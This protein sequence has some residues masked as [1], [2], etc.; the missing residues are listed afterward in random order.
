MGKRFTATEKW[1]KAWFR[2]L[3]PRHKALWEF[4]RDKC[5]AA[6][7]W[8]I[9]MDSATHYVNDL[10]PITMEDFKAFGDRVELHGSD[11]LWLSTFC[12]FQYENLSDKCPAHKPVFKLLRK[13]NLLNRV[14]NRVSNTLQEKEKESD[15]EKELEL[16]KDEGG[17]GETQTPPPAEPKPD[18]LADFEYWTDQV[19]AGNDVPFINLVRNNGIALDGSL[20]RLARDHLG[21]ASRYG[22]HEKT[23]TQHAFRLSLINFLKENLE[24]KAASKK[25]TIPKK[26][27][28]IDDVT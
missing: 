9:D 14:L 11:K 2:K 20:E 23:K 25:Q 24:D 13:Y 21:K 17:M 18:S 6:G 3:P 5:D 15:K 28:T 16:E 4:L 12:D 22:W 8:E 27:L 10:T 1:D 19:I 26:K 7:M